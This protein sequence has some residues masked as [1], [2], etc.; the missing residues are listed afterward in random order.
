MSEIINEYEQRS[1]NKREE[2]KVSLDLELENIMKKHGLPGELNV[3]CCVCKR[4]KLEKTTEDGEP[5]Y[6]SIPIEEQ[7]KKTFSHTYCKSCAQKEIK[8]YERFRRE[9]GQ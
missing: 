7:M 1:S 4:V 6:T 3:Q 8:E 5:I 9:Y 2:E